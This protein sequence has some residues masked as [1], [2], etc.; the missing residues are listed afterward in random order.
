MSGLAALL[1]VTPIFGFSLQPPTI[2]PSLFDVQAQV[3]DVAAAADEP[4]ATPSPS[5]TPAEVAA[6]QTAAD[7][8]EEDRRYTEEVRTRRELGQIHRALGIATW[9]AMTA[10]VAL[11]FIQFYNL[12][13]IGAGQDQNPCASGNAVFGQDQCYGIPWPHRIASI[14]TTALYTTT[15]AFSLAFPDPNHVSQGHGDAADR[16][17]IHGILRWVHLAG[18]VAQMVMGIGLT[19]GWFGDRANDYGALQ[20]VGAVH[21]VIGWTTWGAMTAAGAIMLF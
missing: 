17:R 20:T 14:T 19:S 16:M 7:E 1:L 13:G 4:A 18:M 6:R 2:A 11:G 12:Y 8:A 15:F 10:T 3:A 21:Q 5:L 9:G